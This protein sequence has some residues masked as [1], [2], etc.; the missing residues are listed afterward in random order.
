MN[1]VV[2]QL[3]R[4]ESSHVVYQGML[5]WFKLDWLGPGRELLVAKT[6]RVFNS[7]IFLPF[8]CKY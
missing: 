1:E 2:T 3:E 8:R 4:E 5:P 6:T 7:K